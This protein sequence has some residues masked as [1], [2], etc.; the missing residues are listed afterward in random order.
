[1]EFEFELGEELITVCSNSTHSEAYIQNAQK[2][3]K[4][5]KSQWYNQLCMLQDQVSGAA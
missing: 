3:S 5:A 1:M 2:H 4:Y